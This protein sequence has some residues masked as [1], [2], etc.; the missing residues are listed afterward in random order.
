MLHLLDT[1]HWR[2]GDSRRD[3]PNTLPGWTIAFLSVQPDWIARERLCTLIWPDASEA[4]ARH[5]LRVNLYRVRGVLSDWGVGDAL[6]TERTRVRLSL[7]TDV[8]DFRAASAAAGTDA[9]LAL[10]RGPFLSG[11]DLP[12]FAAFQEWLDLE[13]DASRSQ[14]REAVLASL[15]ASALPAAQAVALCQALLAADPLDDEALVHLLRHLVDLGRAS[16]AR[17]LFQEFE[18]RV[19]AELAADLSPALQAL[20]ASLLQSPA[21]PRATPA[22]DVFVGRTVELGQLE[23]MLGASEGRVLTIVGPGGVGKSRLAR[24]LAKRVAQREGGP[25][26]WVALADLTTAAGA[27]PR[28]AEQIGLQLAPSRD[29]TAQLVAALAARRGTIVLDNAEHLGELPAL[30]VELQQASPASTWLVTSR[31]PLGIAGERTY[32]LDGMEGP[33]P[34][35]SVERFEQA[36]SFEAMRLLES[37]AQAL[38]PDFELAE[39]WAPCLALIRAVGGWPLAI[40]L[41]ASALAQHGADA[42]LA[43]LLRSIDALAA[44]HAPRQAR[45]D[46]MRASL[47]L[48]WRLLAADEEAALAGLSVFRG[49]FTRAA[50][51]AVSGCSSVTLARLV[52]RSLV[53]VVAGGRFDLHPL[54]AQFAAERLVEQAARRDE[55]L[56]RHGEHFAARLQACVASGVQATAAVLQELA[57]DFENVRAA[58]AILVASGDTARLAVAARALSDF[59]TARGRTQELKQLV[60]AAMPATS[61][62]ALARNAL[63]QAAAILHFRGG[64]LDSARALAR[65]ALEAAIAAGDEPGQRSMLNTLALALKD[66][67][68]Y[69]EAERCARDALR[70]ARAAGAEREV[71]SCANTC[72]ILAKTRGDNVEAAALYEE[73]IALHRRSG[74]QRGLAVCLNNLGNVHRALDDGAA[75]QRCF[76]EALRVCEQHGIASTR[77]F[78]LLN[79]GIVHQRAGRMALATSFAQRARAEPAAELAVLLAADVLETLVAIDKHD[80][81]AARQLLVSLALRARQTGHHAALLETVNCHAKLLAALGRREEAIARFIYLIAHPQVPDMQRGDSRRALEGLAATADERSAAAAAAA[82]FEL[83]LLV[84]DVVAAAELPR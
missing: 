59:G 15:A 48:S 40:E 52:E 13:R 84:E 51:E 64:D 35:E 39:Q 20:G 47:S 11:I 77:S 46:S 37:R 14:W 22:R 21:A 69:E 68:R 72:A 54:V 56:R 53:H 16:E 80:F 49:G 43:E 29:A 83:D 74:E 71:A 50:A 18:R 55:V 27:I 4:E 57:V 66:L 12:G 79:L 31:A 81:E 34:G 6:E 8:A 1:P 26:P 3:L 73:A 25:V 58:W 23:A 63:L 44:G 32:A 65:D 10:Y 19:R 60:A 5:S 36:A 70:R 78:A 9:R 45:H 7:P 17:R 28:L 2:R 62:D 30:L 41:A 76:E 38:D 82:R 33:D 61:N 75:A 67:G 24:E 42:V